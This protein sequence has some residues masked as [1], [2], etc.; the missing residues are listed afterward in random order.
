V[1]P[2]PRLFAA[3]LAVCV[4]SCFV[5]PAEAT[6]IRVIG[7]KGADG[8]NGS[9]WSK[10]MKTV[11]AA[12]ARAVS[13]DQV[14]VAGDKTHPYSERISLKNGVQVYGAFPGNLTDAGVVFRPRPDRLRVDTGRRTGR[15]RG[16]RHE[17]RD[18]FDH[19]GRI[20][21]SERKGTVWRRHSVRKTPLPTY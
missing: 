17:R 16:D 18:G 12:I 9:T 15:K 5:L 6:I 3:I 19:F 4:L 1:N 13:G 10:S 11:G 14:W 2:N 21:D 20:H 8:N 7:W